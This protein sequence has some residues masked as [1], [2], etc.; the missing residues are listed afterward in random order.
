MDCSGIAHKL[1]R[2]IPE[3][4]H[5]MVRNLDSSRAGVGS[6]LSEAMVQVSGC[7]PYLA[8]GP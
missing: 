6:L 2:R 8:L 3:T 1:E 4:G 5:S 7:Q